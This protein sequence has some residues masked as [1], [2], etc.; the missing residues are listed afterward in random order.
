MRYIDEAFEQQS[1]KAPDAIA[2]E[3]QQQ[4]LTYSELKDRV[5]H[6]ANRLRRRGVGPGVLVGIF[7]ERSIDIVVCVLGV[8]KSGGAFVPF[9][10]GHPPKR[11]T[12]MLLDAM[13]QVLL[14]HSLLRD[15]LPEHQ[16]SVCFI[17]DDEPLEKVVSAPLSERS[18][19]DVA[20]VIYTSGSTGQ[21]KGVQ[22]EHHSVMNLIA[23]IRET[24]A[25]SALDTLLSVTTIAFDIAMLE[26]FLPLSCGARVVIAGRAVVSDG[27]ALADLI[28]CCGATVLQGTPTTFRMLLDTGWVGSP[29]LTILCGG[30][31]WSRDLADQL[32]LRC[33]SLWNMYGPTE[34]T[35]WSSAT[36]I[37]QGQP[38]VIGAPI[39]NTSFYVL[40]AALKLVPIGVAGELHIAGEGVAR[41]YLRR[42]ELTESRFVRDPFSSIKGARMYRTGDRVRRLKDG[43]IEFL[44]RLDSQVKIRGHRVELGEI[45]ARLSHHFAIEH[46]VVVVRDDSTNTGVISAYF[47]KRNGI[48]VSDKELR[49]YLAGTLPPYMIP[50]MFVPMDSLP[51][52]LNGK[53]DRKALPQPR[54][55]VGDE[56]DASHKPNTATE[57]ALAGIWSSALGVQGLSTRDNFYGLGGHSLL[58]VRVVSEINQK[59]NVQLDVPTFFQN[60]TIAKLARVVDERRTL[61]PGA[62][63]TRIHNGRVG[64]RLYFVCA[65]NAELPLAQ[66]IDRKHSVYT[67][68]TP[69]P[70]NWRAAAEAKQFHAMPN[71]N[72]L[73]SP[74]ILALRRHAGD[75]P[76]LLAGFSFG[77]ILAFEAARQLRAEGRRVEAVLLLDTTA[78]W[79]SG[80]LRSFGAR[81][82]SSLPSWYE[83]KIRRWM[84]SRRFRADILNSEAIG[85]SGVLTA[86]TDEMGSPVPWSLLERLY[87]KASSTYPRRRL[88]CRGFLFLC[89]ASAGEPKKRLLGWD[90][91][92]REGLATVR[93]PGDHMDIIRRQDVM[94][95]V[96]REIGKLL[97]SSETSNQTAVRAAA[98]LVSA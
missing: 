73:I 43:T 67:V 60:Q 69:L 80:A 4:R 8:L 52:T 62:A 26:I 89:D 42:E 31:Q 17:D 35:I 91:I 58:V 28:E 82:I 55:L 46:C 18:P 22:V 68:S 3:Y 86:K 76:C 75:E 33:R 72:D 79:P 59:M 84:A 87:I 65:E 27:V 92:F 21:P 77:G 57:R 54:L 29:G 50:S 93:V 19:N 32:L 88:D 1:D 34:T 83:V 2:V 95:F 12:S 16:S 20:Y 56:K 81:V 25:V 38:I 64:P 6:L 49:D 9:D 98:D 70:M 7:V 23:S 37:E 51:L 90:G 71:M 24:L 11:L 44:G 14:T 94:L 5:D 97:S 13:P 48:E 78:R 40:D 15:F 96:A 45:E 36:R 53:V 39:R 10:I 30:E 74:Y 41:G 47:V 66:L 85:D 61:S 63:V